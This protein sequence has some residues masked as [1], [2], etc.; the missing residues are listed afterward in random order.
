MRITFI[1]KDIKIEKQNDY[2]LKKLI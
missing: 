1:E 2:L